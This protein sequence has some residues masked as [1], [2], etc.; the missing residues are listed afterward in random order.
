[1]SKVLG[2][3]VSLS[4]QKN[5]SRLLGVC[6]LFFWFKI[7]VNKLEIFIWSPKIGFKTL[8]FKLP[9]YFSDA[10]KSILHLHLVSFQI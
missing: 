7:R 6:F 10:K 8:Q 3:L 1:M 5:C 9:S 4:V 2:V